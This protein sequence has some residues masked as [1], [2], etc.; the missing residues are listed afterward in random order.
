MSDL[1]QLIQ[2]HPD[3]RVLKRALT[4]KMLEQGLSGT[5]ISEILQVSPQYVSKWKGAYAQGGVESLQL[6]YQGSTGYLNEE[7]EQAA[8]AWIGE[9]ETI[10]V[11]ALRDYLE[12]TYGVVYRSKQSYYT[13]LSAGGMS[14][15]QSQPVNPKRDETQVQAQREVIQKNW[16]VTG[17]LSKREK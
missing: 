2:S 4:I 9:H 12:E 6:G 16:R 14:Y 11:A 3:G 5:Q 8:L 17:K 1:E 15:H 7:Q 13:L 10:S